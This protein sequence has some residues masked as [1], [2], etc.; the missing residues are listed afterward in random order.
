MCEG[1]LIEVS[2]YIAAVVITVEAPPSHRAANERKHGPDDIG[3]GER[4]LADGS[5]AWEDA[6]YHARDGIDSVGGDECNEGP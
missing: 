1:L 5:G 6:R 2:R 3:D 4:R